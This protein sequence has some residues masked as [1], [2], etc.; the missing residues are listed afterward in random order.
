MVA[1]GHIGEVAAG[2]SGRTAQLWI[3]VLIFFA[4]WFLTI[5][6]ARK[7]QKQQRLLLDQLR[8]GDEV[9]LACGIFGK[10]VQLDGPR[11]TLEI[12]SGVRIEVL[13]EGVRR[14]L[15]AGE[16]TSK[17]S[18]AERV[19]RVEFLTGG[20][21]ADGESVQKIVVERPRRGRPRKIKK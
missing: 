20:E 6:P 16:K 7:R 18:R 5:A 19:E 13:R 21:G 4:I 8:K 10:I 14:K 2:G 15:A 9:L 11:L 17:A 3:F 1:L 12:A